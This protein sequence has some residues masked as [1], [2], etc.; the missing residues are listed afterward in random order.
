MN[1]LTVHPIGDAGFCVAHLTD[2][3]PIL[4][5]STSITTRSTPLETRPANWSQHPSTFLKQPKIQNL[6][7]K[8]ATASHVSD[9]SL[10]AHISSVSSSEASTFKLK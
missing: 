7:S 4:T 9:T 8:I 6:K 10:I 5:I 2:R 1:Q 3:H